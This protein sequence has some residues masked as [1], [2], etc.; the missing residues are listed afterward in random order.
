MENFE[1]L[2]RFN[3]FAEQAKENL[4]TFAR[5]NYLNGNMYNLIQDMR[6]PTKATT[7]G[8]MAKLCKQ[9]YTAWYQYAVRKTATNSAEFEQMKNW[10]V[11][12]DHAPEKLSDFDCLNMIFCGYKGFEHFGLIRPQWLDLEELYFDEKY[13]DKFFYDDF[14]HIKPFAQ[15]QKTTK[16]IYLNVSLDNVPELINELMQKCLN[17]NEYLYT[18]FWSNNERNDVMLIYTNDEKLPQMMQYL[19]E[20]YAKKPKL[21]LN[22]EG[23]LRFTAKIRDWA[24]ITDDPEYKRS[25]FNAELANAFE[26]FA[27]DY[28]K[29]YFQKI[30]RKFG[31]QN[32]LH[33]TVYS[34]LTSSIANQIKI[35]LN[36]YDTLKNPSEFDEAN[37]KFYAELSQKF[38][39]KDPEMFEKIKN[40]ADTI[41][42]DMELGKINDDA[43]R[44]L[45][46]SS[47]V[48]YLTERDRKADEKAGGVKLAKVNSGQQVLQTFRFKPHIFEQ[49]LD[50]YNLKDEAISN[51]NYAMLA[52]YLEK[53]HLSTD[54]P[55]FNIETL[56]RYKNN[57]QA[58]QVEPAKENAPKSFKNSKIRQLLQ[59]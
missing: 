32:M 22:G 52:P 28:K 6:K 7:F 47:N 53:Q 21:F 16:R 40:L 25:S 30:E 44:W 31:S 43:T 27:I 37:R 13:K 56:A 38:L 55:F 42:V 2:T 10:V 20:I 57:V 35:G 24:G 8:E 33:E 1:D 5:K 15:K 49:L 51:I 29:M 19:D 18:K 54:Y 46:V 9:V 12:K 58:L 11:K 3:T 34:T 17:D 4:V 39:T 23:D 14:F 26:N 48:P 59:K 50:K 36:H 41:L 45:Q